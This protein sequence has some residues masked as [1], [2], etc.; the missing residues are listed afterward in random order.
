M[1]IEF[2]IQLIFMIA[3]VSVSVAVFAGKL[4]TQIKVIQVRLDLLEGKMDKH[5]N[6]QT[7]MA[8]TEKATEANQ[9]INEQNQQEI[10]E[11]R[12]SLIK[13]ERGERTFV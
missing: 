10:R 3:S 8:L 7:R 5:N 2:I 9:R 13:T 11:I 6:L 12:N 4:E 1:T